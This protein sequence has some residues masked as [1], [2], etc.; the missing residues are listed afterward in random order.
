MKLKEIPFEVEDNSEHKKIYRVIMGGYINDDD[1]AIAQS[2]YDKDEFENKV[3]YCLAFC[4][5]QINCN[6]FEKYEDLELEDSIFYHVMIKPST[7]TDYIED[8]CLDDILPIPYSTENGRY[9]TAHTIRFINVYYYDE[10]GI[11]Y[12]VNLN[13]IKE[14]CKYKYK[15]DPYAEW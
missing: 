11:E 13:S 5:D 3:A 4:I 1:M 2:E 6:V 9:R 10:N 7:Y 12:E 14:L 15:V 8:E